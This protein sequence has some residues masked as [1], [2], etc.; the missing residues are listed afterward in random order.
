[1]EFLYVLLLGLAFHR[2][3]AFLPYALSDTDD[4]LFVPRQ[5]SSIDPPLSSAAQSRGIWPSPQGTAPADTSIAKTSTWPGTAPASLNSVLTSFTAL[6]YNDLKHHQP[7]LDKSKLFNYASFQWCIFQ[8]DIG[9]AGTILSCCPN[10]TDPSNLDLNFLC[11][12]NFVDPFNRCL[13]KSRSEHAKHIHCLTASNGEL[14]TVVVTTTPKPDTSNRATMYPS[15]SSQSSAATAAIPTDTSLEAVMENVTYHLPSPGE[16][17]VKVMLLDGSIAQLMANKVIIGTQSVT[18]PSDLTSST[19]LPGGITAKPGEATK[20]DDD[21][22]HDGGVVGLF[23]ALGG[24]AKGTT[25][26]VG[27]A[28]DGIGAVTTGALA[29]AGGTT[30]TAASLSAPLSGAIGEMGKFV[31]SINSIHKSFPGSQLTQAALDTFNGAK[32]LARQSLNWMKSTQNLVQNFDKLPVEVQSQV[33]NRA[34]EFLKTGGTLAQCKAALEA[35]QDFPWEEAKVPN[36]TAEV[37]ATTKPMEKTSIQS[38]P[39]MSI[40]STAQST[41]IQSSTATTSTMQSSSSTTTSSQSSSSTSGSPTPTAFNDTT[42]TI[43]TKPGTSSEAFK[44]FVSE[45]DGGKGH[46]YDFVS[47]KRHMYLTN[48]NETQASELKQQYSFIE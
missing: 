30:G 37:S 44:K 26:A 40:M 1:M 42:H 29:F 2:V 32:K 7:D 39:V 8:F 23:G 12:S 16:D 21:D 27:G 31:S 47:D 9:A 11:I 22:Q 19:E 28:V 4:D 17:A 13:I 20:P 25:S 45:L 35:F 33:K 14:S 10:L 3:Y 24:I 15:Q 6:D 48:L 34:G 38:I 46:L 18:I 41:S 36:Q 5:A 43:F